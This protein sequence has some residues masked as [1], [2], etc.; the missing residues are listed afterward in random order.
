MRDFV[1]PD[2]PDEV[3]DLEAYDNDWTH[4]RALLFGEFLACRNGLVVSVVNEP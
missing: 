2:Q 1:A 4:S 3:S